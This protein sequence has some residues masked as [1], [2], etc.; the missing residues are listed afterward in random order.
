[1]KITASLLLIVGW[2]PVAAQKV[3]LAPPLVQYPSVFFA[4]SAEVSMKFAMKGASIHYTMDESE[5]SEQSPVYRLP[6][7]I[8]DSRTTLSAKVFAAGYLPSDRVSATFIA[9]GLRIA[10]AEF[11]EADTRFQGN[12]ASTLIDNIGG[13]AA[14]GNKSWLGYHDDSVVIHVQLQKR[15]AV[16]SVLLDFLQDHGSWVFLPQQV[17]VRYFDESTQHFAEFGTQD[18]LNQ[19]VIQGAG[20]VP[21]VIDAATPVTTNRL[22]VIIKVL[23]SIPDG[24][25]GKGTKSWIFIDEIKVY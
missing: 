8:K 9:D 2:L 23:Q 22:Q 24:H 13:I 16:S 12:G 7:K 25:P 5:P 1:M 15:E 4:D 19:P 3:Q 11:P 10:N 14:I 21:Q 17:T 18:N 6:I 20:C